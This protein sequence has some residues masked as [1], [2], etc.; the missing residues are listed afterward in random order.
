MYH[1]HADNPWPSLAGK[2]GHPRRPGLQS[3]GPGICFQRSKGF[4]VLKARQ[5]APAR[6]EGP[7]RCEK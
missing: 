4:T 2:H 5:S 6:P 7:Q 1:W 3:D